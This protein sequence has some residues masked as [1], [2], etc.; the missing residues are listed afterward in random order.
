MGCKNSKREFVTSTRMSG[1]EMGNLFDHRKILEQAKQAAIHVE[2]NLDDTPNLEEHGTDEETSS[3]ESECSDDDGSDNDSILTDDDVQIEEEQEDLE[4]ETTIRGRRPSALEEPGLYL[5]NQSIH[6]ISNLVRR[7][8][9]EQKGSS[10]LCDEEDAS[11]VPWNC[12]TC[13]YANS[14]SDTACEMCGTN[15]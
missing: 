2:L 7:S 10:F 15:K 13:N 8:G 5:I 12:S 11:F 9:I 14:G 3:S 6:T 1:M 4:V